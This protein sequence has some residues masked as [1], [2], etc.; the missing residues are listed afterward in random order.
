MKCN[1]LQIKL[2]IQIKK[3]SIA[4][5]ISNGRICVLTTYLKV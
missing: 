5:K 3:K 2:I 4:R 1:E